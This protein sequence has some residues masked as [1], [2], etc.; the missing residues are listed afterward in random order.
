[1]NNE[2]QIEHPLN[3]VLDSIT[4]TDIQKMRLYFITKGVRDGEKA[5]AK[6][7]NSEKT[8][9]D[10]HEAIADDTLKESFK[11]VTKAKLDSLIKNP[12]ISLE[13]YSPIVDDTKKI[14]T[15]E[16]KGKNKAF[17]KLIEDDLRKGSD[18]PVIESM[19]ELFS[20]TLWAYCIAYEIDQDTFIYTFTRISKSTVATDETT[21]RIASL[22][23]TKKVRLEILNNEEIVLFDKSIDSIYYDNRFMVMS[24]NKFEVM[25]QIDEEF[26]QEAKEI[27]EHLEG[28]GCFA[29]LH[30]I[31]DSISTNSNMLRKFACLA[32]SDRYKSLSTKEGIRKIKEAVE[33]NGIPLK[34]TENGS[35]VLLES[36]DDVEEVIKVLSGFYGIEI[37]T[38]EL[39]G[40]YSSVVIR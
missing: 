7:L 4:N 40:S 33:E 6:K 8:K 3:V 22:F 36:K 37:V 38:H 23:K 25:I 24:K 12:E 11:E 10:I 28:S 27:F 31:T 14:F 2:T 39:R 13:E 16:M 32:K 34:F 30:H 9:F 1:M 19:N 18:V 35:Q 21:L 17:A 26:T 20:K 15:Y 5:N 29:G